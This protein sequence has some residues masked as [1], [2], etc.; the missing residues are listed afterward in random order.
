MLDELKV[1]SLAP[2]ATIF[3]AEASIVIVP[4]PLEGKPL[5]PAAKKITTSYIKQS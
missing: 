2:T 3:L 4:A 5:F 1:V